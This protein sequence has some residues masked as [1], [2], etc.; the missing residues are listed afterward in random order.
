MSYPYFIDKVT[1]LEAQ[2]W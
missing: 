1:I 2:T